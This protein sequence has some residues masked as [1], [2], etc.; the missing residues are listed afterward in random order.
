MFSYCIN[1]IGELDLSSWKLS[2][3]TAYNSAFYYCM[4]L[5]K[6]NISEWDFT[7]ATS[8]ATMFYYCSALE[9]LIMDNIIPITST[10][11]NVSQIFWCCRSLK[12]ATLIG[13][14]FSKAP[15][16]GLFGGCQTI[17]ELTL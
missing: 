7:K 4:S 2:L 17:E 14:N 13:W 3:V 9:E 16:Y 11:T 15:A 5:K 12:S 10:C 8:C 1:L 6:V